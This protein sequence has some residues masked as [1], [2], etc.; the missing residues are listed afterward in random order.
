[1]TNIVSVNNDKVKNIVK[2]HNKKTRDELQQFI[3]EGEELVRDAVHN[4]CCVEI[5][6]T[7]ED[8][9]NAIIVNEMV[10]K[11]MS[12]MKS[13][14]QYLALCKYIDNSEITSET[15]VVLDGIQDPGNLGTIIRTASCF[16]VKVIY[17]SDNCADIYNLKTLRSTMGSVFKVKVIRKNIDDIYKE[18]KDLG[19]EVY[20]T[21]LHEKSIYLN[22]TKIPKKSA[23]VFGNEGKGVSENT[24]SNTD[25]FI[26]VKINNN[27]SLNVAICAGIVLNEVANNAN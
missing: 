8:Y 6:T 11:K 12:Q 19:Y 25:K 21:T 17:I 2:L 7:N 5:Y 4:G 9:T 22:E 1:M 15:V 20:T 24:I 14:T 27:D 13:P 26:K 10:M 18:I 3:V 23:I 16:D